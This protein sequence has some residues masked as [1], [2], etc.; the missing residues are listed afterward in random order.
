MPKR[1]A[2]QI[3]EKELTSNKK[4][5]SGKRP[6]QAPED[7]MGDFEDEWEDEVDSNE[8]TID[9]SRNDATDNEDGM[10]IVSGAL[11]VFLPN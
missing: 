3:D 7:E 1:P 2:S 11:V 10:C 4:K 5:T 8:N 9:G 6:S